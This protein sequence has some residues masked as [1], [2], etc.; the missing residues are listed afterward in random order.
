MALSVEASELVEIFM[1]LSEKQ[2][3]SLTEQQLAAASDELA[4]ILIYLL[5]I[6]DVLG[7]DLLKAAATK[8]KKNCIKY[9]VEKGHLLAEPI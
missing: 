2:A 7:I 5:R 9:P 8:M 4:D 1:W 6:A 3:S